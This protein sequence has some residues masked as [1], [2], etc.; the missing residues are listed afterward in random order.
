MPSPEPR[1]IPV[2]VLCGGQG[3]R[4]GEI[5]ALRPKPMLDI[6][7]RPM[8]VHIMACY[9][10]F[11]FRRFILCTGHRSD[12]INAYFLNF[13]AHNADF[14]LEL[15]S[16]AVSYHQRERLPDWQV[17]L[18]FTGLHAMTGARLARAAAH[19]LG[20]AEHFAV[21]YGD[22]LTDADL[23]D[24]FRWHVAHERLGTVLGV[25]PP[26]QFGRFALHEDGSASFAEKPRRSAE[27]VNGGFFFFRRG[28]LDYLSAE[29]DCVLEQEP[30]QRLTFDGQLQV[31]RHGGFWS[32][33]DT[34]RDRDEVQG[35]WE[36]GAAPWK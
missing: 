34:L 36:A 13:V 15:A 24:E 35:L 30:L 18:T 26:S 29:D 11:G 31:Y 7:E 28:F 5:G 17:T 8:L 1:D 3:S 4:L 2:F 33:V 10:R 25:R 22:G 14:T 20:E 9:G 16:Q 23:A 32:C 27:I 6:G 21:T 19:Y 12:V